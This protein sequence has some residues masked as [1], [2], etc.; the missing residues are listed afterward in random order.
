M[1]QFSH[2]ESIYLFVFA[3]LVDILY[4]HIHICQQYY[5]PPTLA[6]Y[7]KLNLRI[8]YILRI[9]LMSHNFLKKLYIFK[10]EYHIFFLITE[11]Q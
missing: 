6:Q 10:S 7:L 8:Q 5:T 9:H 1:F 3:L 4:I 2:S 11:E